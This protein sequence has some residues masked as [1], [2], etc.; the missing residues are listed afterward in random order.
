M[1]RHPSSAPPDERGPETVELERRLLLE[2]V[3]D[4]PAEGQLLAD[5]VDRLGAPLESAASACQALVSDG[6]AVVEG[7]RVRASAAA[8]R[9]DALLPVAL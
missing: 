6:L 7:D 3:V 5:L 9:F 8:R 1:H 2:L 4:A